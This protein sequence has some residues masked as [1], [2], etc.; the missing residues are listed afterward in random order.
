MATPTIAGNWKMNGSAPEARALATGL[1]QRLQE[2]GPGIQVV[3]CPPFVHLGLVKECLDGSDIG[4]GAQNM[5]HR[6]SGAF[7]GEVSPAMLTE[8]CDFVILG[9]SERRRQFGETDR[10]VNEKV[11]AALAAGLRPIVC[12]GESREQREAGDAAKVVVQQL[13]A[14]L[15]GVAEPA[16]LLVAYEPLWA[17]GTGVPATPK[18][19]EEVMSSAIFPVLA[20]LF[21]D[22]GAAEVPLLYGGSITAANVAEFVAEPFIHGALV[23]GASLQADEFAEIVHITARVKGGG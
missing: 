23:G 9:H 16:G 10:H 2:I 3:L 14:A 20:A 6:E 18:K 12:V 21:G 13:Q 7:T 5:H 19:A 4:V 22:H 8:L 15:E 1:R 11:V 17:I